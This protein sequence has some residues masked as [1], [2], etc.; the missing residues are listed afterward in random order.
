MKK[1]SNQQVRYHLSFWVIYIVLWSA[2]DLVYHP[3]ILGNMLLNL[4]FSLSVAPFIYFNIFY[5][6]PKYL[7]KRKLKVYGLYFA[8]MFILMFVVRYVVYQFTFRSIINNLETAER[9][10][11]GDGLVILASEN[12]ILLMITTALFIIREYYVKEKYAIELEQKNMESE[13]RMLKSQLQPHFLFNNL[14]TIYFL[15]ET[16]PTL[17]KEVM[18]QFSDVLSHQ[19]YNAKKDKVYLKEELDSLEN[20]LKIQQVRHE[21]FLN[22]SYKFPA[23]PK[24]L[25]IAPMILLTFVENA[26]KHGQK[27]NGY[28]ID[29]EVE[30]QGTELHLQVSNYFGTLKQEKNGGVGLENVQR[31]L[32]LI[33]PNKH[34][35]NIN[36]KEDKYT[37][38]LTITL[39][40]N[41]Q[42]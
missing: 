15:M 21:D 1:K 7:L 11:S 35:L 37:V 10:S 33:Y 38:D 18:I 12:L 6:I 31:R 19:L 42:A 32:S 9:F 28:D 17:A 36:K 34:K 23:N 16:N 2:R 40:K 29:I 14:N 41:G 4:A 26:F 13:L 22:L 5:L 25:Q 27:E 30:L 39:D 24:G 8:L 20:F 3:D